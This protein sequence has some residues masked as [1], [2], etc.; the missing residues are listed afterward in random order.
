MNAGAIKKLLSISYQISMLKHTD[1]IFRFNRV[2]HG[3][4]VA[5][6]VA[7]IAAVLVLAAVPPVDRDALTHHL[8][9]P[10]LYLKH[11]GIYEIPLIPFSYYPMN[12]DLIYLVPLAFGN[13]IVP[14]YIH[15]AFALL[16]ATLIFSFLRRRLENRFYGLLGALM[17]LSLPVVV[18]LSVTVY[19]DLGL[20]FFSTASLLQLLRWSETHHRL[21]HL[22]WAGTF[23]GLC[24][25]TKPNGMLV[26]FFLVLAVP[27]LYRPEVSTPSLPQPEGQRKQSRVAIA[28][29]PLGCSFAFAVI[30][31]LVFSPWLLRNYIWTGNPVFPMAQA[32]FASTGRANTGDNETLRSDTEDLETIQNHVEG[33][34]SFGHFAGRK[35][36]F[37][38]TLLEV[39]SIPLRVFF[40]GQDDNPRLFDGKL[41]PYLLVF[42]LIAVWAANGRRRSPRIRLEIRL[43][44]SFSLLYLLFAF[45]LVDMRI[46][47]IAPIIPP[48]VILAVI[49]IQDLVG[50]ITSRF[51][52]LNQRMAMCAAGV[53]FLGLL[54]LNAA[55]LVDQFGIVDPVSYLRGDISREAYILKH[56]PEY[57]AISFANRNL[58]ENSRIL[59]LFNG[60]RI[61]YSER[62]LICDNESFRRAVHAS[63]S[64]ADLVQRLKGN[65]ISY[66]LVRADLFSQW[67]ESQFKPDQKAVLQ[68]LF[69]DVLLRLY[70]GHGYVLFAV[71][72]G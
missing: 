23:A 57:A 59:A 64:S 60:N 48:L 54:G 39:L 15:F 40:Q 17:F 44:G 2:I 21:R 67:A 49:G 63:Q 66:L 20:I 6:L 12:L 55:Y 43:L 31:I 26:F 28:L 53:V 14:K 35:M 11:G 69:G 41:N 16:T 34:S 61:Y 3:L 68:S 24:L 72:A 29:R 70:Q 62:E 46:R 71:T 56:R 45:F 8:A 47:Y 13:D 19:V 27:F 1:G 32:I 65:G 36:I 33:G 7:L 22:V 4:L 30:A 38:E 37:G 9:V 18:K 42:P 58:P 52:K 10:K 51:S 25:G 50:I 5:A